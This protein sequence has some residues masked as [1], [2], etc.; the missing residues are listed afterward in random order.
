[1]SNSANQLK[2]WLALETSQF[3]RGVA[4]P[5]L[6]TTARAFAAIT[7]EFDAKTAETVAYE[8]VLHPIIKIKA[9]I[10]RGRLS[11]AMELIRGHKQFL[12]SGQFCAEEAYELLAEEMRLEAMRGN[13][14]KSLEL[15]DHLLVLEPTLLARLEL[16]QVAALCHFEIGDFSRALAALDRTEAL[17]ESFRYS[18]ESLYSKILKCKILARTEGMDLGRN[19][20]NQ[21]WHAQIESKSLTLNALSA[22]L[23]AEID[24]ARLESRTCL[25]LAHASYLIAEAM[26]EKYYSALAF[27]DYYLSLPVSY[28]PFLEARLLT[29]SSEFPRIETVLKEL[30]PGA[31]FLSTSVSAAKGTPIINEVGDVTRSF[32][33]E[34]HHGLKTIILCDHQI[35]IRLNP[36]RVN[37]AKS[38]SQIFELAS[39]LQ[40]ET[41]EKPKLFEVLW[42][43]QKYSSLKHDGLIRSLL[44]RARKR[45]DID[46]TINKE[47]VLL[48]STLVVSSKSE[49]K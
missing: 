8:P 9:L 34:L 29:L 42:G 13:W 48:N 30:A 46:A 44:H 37:Y 24:F 45:F 19:L 11:E 32:R 15:I 10:F 7:L 5:G 14:K 36:F 27:L 1:M 17:Q 4:Q 38:Q 28:R 26:G 21:L 20:L 41:V 39:A 23:R 49:T 33:N 2:N 43:K 22:L 47:G 31:A 6:D 35:I 18:D 12:N 3:S 16:H 40:F 25:S